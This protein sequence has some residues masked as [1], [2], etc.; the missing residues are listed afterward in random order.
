M[1]LYNRT[2][3][4]DELLYPL[5]VAAGRS[6]GA[7]TA[8]VVVKITGTRFSSA[9][10]GKAS[11]Y[12]S[13]RRG[14][15]TGCS[16]H[17][18]RISCDGFFRLVIPTKPIW[19]DNDALQIAQR[20]YEIAQHE[21]GHVRDYQSTLPDLAW[22]HQRSYRRRPRWADRPEEKRAMKYVQAA[23]EKTTNGQLCSRDD[24][25]L[26]LALWYIATKKGK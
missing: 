14:F 24:L 21:F 1:K 15:L 6:V 12:T 3:I 20:V 25:I 2:K 26:N 9:C 13:V 16:R 19:S 22:S 7:R 10:R 4:P 5:L 23:S 17:K 18:Q 8:K 11:N